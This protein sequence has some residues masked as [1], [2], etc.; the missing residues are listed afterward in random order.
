MKHINKILTVL[1]IVFF[2]Y[3]SYLGVKIYHENQLEKLVL[4]KPQS[5]EYLSRLKNSENKLKDGDK[6]NDFEALFQI[7]FD[8]EALRDHNG[9]IEYYKKAL[10]ISSNS[11]LAKWNLANIYKEI[12]NREGAEKAYKEAIVLEPGNLQY[13]NGL[14]EL[15]RNWPEKKLEEP[16]LYLRALEKDKE[17]TGLMRLLAG[18]FNGID[19]DLNAKYWEGEIAKLQN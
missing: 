4:G 19:D 11:S 12:G 1:I 16:A 18:Y 6:N 3:L 5:Q 14:G 15:Y 7:A 9:A 10:K 17:N 8:R 13:Y 2:G